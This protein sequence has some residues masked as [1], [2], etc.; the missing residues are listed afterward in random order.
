MK[1]QN[2]CMSTDGRERRFIGTTVEVRAS[3]R[4]DGIGV[5]R[6]Y[7]AKYNEMSLDLGGWFERIAPGAFLAVLQDDCR[8]LFNHR[9]EAI[10]GRS[11]A[12][13]L[14][15]KDDDVGLYY[16][17]DLPDT[18]CGRDTRVSVARRDI[19]GCSFAFTVAPDG[20]EWDF[21]SQV[22]V[23]TIKRFARLYDVGPVTYPAYESTEVDAR[24][25]ERA[26]QGRKAIPGNPVS[27]SLSLANA[28]PPT[29]R[30]RS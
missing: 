10:L 6:G 16:E 28:A 25:F 17:C 4:G 27:I 18:Q 3:K 24:S 26:L 7:S 8:C 23:R 15:L 11:S 1:P 21:N 20:E 29:R 5:L 13:T 19:T 22:A 14:Q 30:G 9:S 12:G 2:I